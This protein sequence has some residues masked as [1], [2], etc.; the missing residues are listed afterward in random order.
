MLIIYNLYIRCSIL[1][2]SFES[3]HSLSLMNL[4]KNEL[5]PFV[6]KLVLKITVQIF[7][8][9]LRTKKRFV[10]SSKIPFFLIVKWLEERQVTK[11]STS[12]KFQPQSS[13]MPSQSISS[14]PA[15]LRHQ[16]GQSLLRQVT[17]SRC[18]R[19]TQT[20]GSSAPPQSPA[21]STS[22]RTSLLQD[23]HSD[24]AQ[25]KTQAQAQ[26]TT[27]LHPARSSAQS[28]S[29]SRRLDSFP[30]LTAAANSQERDTSSSTKSL[31][32]QVHSK[33]TLYIIIYKLYYFIYW[34]M[35]IRIRSYL[36]L[37]PLSLNIEKGSTS[38]QGY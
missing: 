11:V 26:S 36:I 4:M 13:S 5:I 18:H 27:K 22:T 32:Q 21:K 23:F 20:G 31:L 15:S 29:S 2:I 35:D 14:N 24:M 34:I 37:F 6:L 7:Q 10:W 9:F 1:R 33:S 8:F 12:A 25:T 38:I 30:K 16:N 28:S 3:Y 19:T 17:S